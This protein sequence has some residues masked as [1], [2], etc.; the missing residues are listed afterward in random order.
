MSIALAGASAKPFDHSAFDKLLKSHVHGKSVDYRGLK[1]DRAELVDY[2]DSLSRADVASLSR[3]EKMSLFLNAYNACTLLLIVEHY[4]PDLSS[5]K[6]IP[7]AKRWKAKRWNVGGR[8]F[9]L[10]DM[11]H[12]VLRAEFEDARIHTAINCASKGCPP[13]RGEAFVSDRL[14]AQ[15]DEQMRAFVNDPYYV[16]VGD[17]VLRVSRIF[18]W[19]KGDFVRD[20]GSVRKF[21]LR[22]ADEKLKRVAGTESTTVRY[23]PYD[24]ALNDLRREKDD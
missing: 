9:S 22:F 18:K 17:G 24:W 6:D 3:D 12:K 8:L 13:L 21:I 4:S 11:E 20:A 16:S 2:V 15:L 1:S 5:I 23:I 14:D 19:F 7:K 10:D